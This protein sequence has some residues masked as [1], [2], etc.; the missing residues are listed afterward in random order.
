MIPI[1]GQHGG[2]LSA[3]KNVS[4]LTDSERD[5]ERLQ[6][7]ETTIDL[8]D[9]SDIPGQENITVAPLGELADTTISSDD[10]EGARL[11]GKDDPND[12]DVTPEEIEVLRKSADVYPSQ[13]EEDL[14][15]SAL[16]D[17][18]LEGDPLNEQSMGNNVSGGDLDVPGS[19]GSDDPASDALGQGDEEN[20]FYSMDEDEEQAET[21]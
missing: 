7:E 19:E 8:P 20:S 18:D 9:V 21:T 4:D 13:D 15:R 2:T 16:D 12:S 11:F 5:Q 10:E 14:Q 1:P 3:S 6:H 17:T